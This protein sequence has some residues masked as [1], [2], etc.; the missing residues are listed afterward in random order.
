MWR[1][2][3]PPTQALGNLLGSWAWSSILQ[4]PLWAVLVWAVLVHSLGPPLG[5][6]GGRQGEKRRGRRGRDLKDRRIREGAEGISSTHLGPGKLARLPG[7]FL[8]SPG[9]PPSVGVLGS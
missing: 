8:S 2:F 9:P 3:T 5:C 4:G 7:L 1:V 6:I